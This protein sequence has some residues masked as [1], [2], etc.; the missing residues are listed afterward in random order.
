[1]NFAATAR[2]MRAAEV[3]DDQTS[4][5]AVAA[6]E[7]FQSF[8]DAANRLAGTLVLLAITKTRLSLDVEIHYAAAALMERGVEEY[9]Q[10]RPTERSAHFHRHLG[11]AAGALRVTLAEMQKTLAKSALARDPLPPLQ[12][13]W[14]ELKSAA[15]CLPGFDVIDFKHSC[16]AMHQQS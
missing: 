6:Q 1:M 9:R 15:R 7:C 4:A 10:L 5:Y 12:E 8:Q 13:A 2:S 14:G 16:C 11:A 3:L